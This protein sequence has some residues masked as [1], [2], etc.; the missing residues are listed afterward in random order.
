ME[1]KI[2][3]GTEGFEQIA[4]VEGKKNYNGYIL[5]GI[6]L[7]VCI[8]VFYLFFTSKNTDPSAQSQQQTGSAD[9]H[10]GNDVAQLEKALAASPTF[11]N[12]VNLGVAYQNAG[13]P[14]RSIPLFEKA[15]ELQPGS[16]IAWNDLGVG[17][18]MIKQFP[19]AEQALAKA[20]QLDPEFQLAKNNIAWLDQERK[21]FMEELQKVEAVPEAERTSKQMIELGLKY[22][23]IGDYQKSI[24]VFRKCI[25]KDPGSSLA[26]NNLGTSYMF[27]KN[28]P[29]AIKAFEKAIELEP[30]EGLYKNNLKWAKDEMAAATATAPTA[31]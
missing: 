3:T 9:Q 23:S 22:Y 5:A 21:V 31:Q 20:I 7:L 16:A 15:I 30:Q 27:L 28:Y 10:A 18:L 17:Y 6:V 8:P 1:E 14:K 11:R 19:E 29:E 12:Y 2:K 26:Y 4:G 13:Q 25:E 24:D